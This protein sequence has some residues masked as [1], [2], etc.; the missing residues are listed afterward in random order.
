MAFENIRKNR[1]RFLDN[2]A[3]CLTQEGAT[4]LICKDC[5]FY[6]EGE[7]EVLECGGFKIIKALLD[8]KVLTVEEIV[9]VLTE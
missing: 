5:D 7:D 4:E 2:P 8:K 1:K 9:N 3:H 6:K